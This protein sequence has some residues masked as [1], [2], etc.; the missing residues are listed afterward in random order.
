M[1]M[2]V[3]ASIRANGPCWSWFMFGFERLWA[4]LQR[5]MTQ[6]SHPEPLGYLEQI[7][8]VH[9]THHSLSI[10]WQV[11]SKTTQINEIQ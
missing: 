5:W 3:V 10:G 1:I 6:K 9:F 11:A 8:V 7:S 2:H 4:R